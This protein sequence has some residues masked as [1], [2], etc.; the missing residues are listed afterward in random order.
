MRGQMA[1]YDGQAAEYRI[2]R[3][4]CETGHS[5]ANRRWRGRSGEIDLVMRLGDEV[6]FVEVKKARDFDRA[7]ERL[8]PRQIGR[9]QNAALEFLAGEPR[10]MN[11]DMRFD[12]ALVNGQGAFRIVENAL[13]YA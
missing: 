2:E 11:T 4:Y 6:I 13:A 12:V 8:Q 1:Y 5:V 3:H 10:G 7:A 9:L